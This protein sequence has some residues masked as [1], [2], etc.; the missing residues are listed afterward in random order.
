[1]TPLNLEADADEPPEK[2]CS[3]PAGSKDWQND[4]NGSSGLEAEFLGA[5]LGKS[6]EL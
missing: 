1:M 6:R 4:S 2:G 5:C 3:A